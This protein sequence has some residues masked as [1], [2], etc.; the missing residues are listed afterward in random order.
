MLASPPPR[1]STHRAG[2]RPSDRKRRFHG[3]DP[4]HRTSLRGRGYACM[5][6]TLRGC[7]CPPL[8]TR[9][10]PLSVADA[11]VRRCGPNGSVEPIA[12]DYT[13][14]DYLADAAAGIWRGHR[15]YRC[16]R[17]CREHALD[18]TRLAGRHR[19]DRAACPTRSSPLP[20]LERS[21]CRGPAGGACRTP[22]CPRHPPDPQLARRSDA[23]LYAA[24]CDPGRRLVGAA[25]GLLAQIRPVLRPAKLSRADGRAGA[26]DRAPSGHRRSSS[27]IWACR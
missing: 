15:P 7:P 11:A 9:P 19:V 18:E 12:R 21:E 24:R 13:L 8:G 1:L 17:R 3:R 23:H 26:A 16:R 25:I 4:D 10:D 5:T 6:A 20:A 27:T 2:G 22:P 14:D